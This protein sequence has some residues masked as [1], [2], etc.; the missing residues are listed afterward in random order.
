MVLAFALVFCALAWWLAGMTG[1]IA[2]AASIVVGMLGILWVVTAVRGRVWKW[3]WFLPGMFG[4][5]GG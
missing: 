4:G 2:T 3:M 1:F 5:P